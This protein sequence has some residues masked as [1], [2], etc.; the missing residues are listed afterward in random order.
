MKDISNY[1]EMDYFMN[2][3]LS[4][5]VFEINGKEVPVLK[6]FLSVK[7][8]VFRNMFSENRL[9]EEDNGKTSRNRKVI[10]DTIFE[11]FKTFILYLHCDQLILEDDNDIELILEVLQL[12]EN[13][14]AIRLKDKLH[15]QLNKLVINFT[16]LLLIASVGYYYK[17]ED[18]M[19]EV[20]TF[21]KQNFDEFI[22]KNINELEKWNKL[23]ESR[24]SKIMANNYRKINKQFNRLKI[25]DNNQIQRQSFAS[26]PKEVSERRTR[27]NR[28]YNER[29]RRTLFGPTPNS[30]GSRVHNTLIFNGTDFDTINYRPL[31]RKNDRPN[32]KKAEPIERQ[33]EFIHRVGYLEVLN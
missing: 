29:Q 11:A 10:K 12:T 21:I 4:D 2:Q 23:T 33:E 30:S 28:I 32:P 1:P 6:A 3:E 20:L 22:D 24:V 5:F 25:S 7:S 14:E 27:P 9:E 17:W 16:N 13:Y 15:K 26:V 19:S 31:S 18:L 8:R